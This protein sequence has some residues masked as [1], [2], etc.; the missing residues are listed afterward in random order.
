MSTPRAQRSTAVVCMR[1]STISGARNLRL[2]TRLVVGVCTRVHRV[3]ICTCL[4]VHVCGGHS[5]IPQASPQ[6]RCAPHERMQAD[7]MTGNTFKSDWQAGW[8]A[9]RRRLACCPGACTRLC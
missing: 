3:H 7:T 6:E 8:S 5:N 4:H 9:A 1:D 2:R